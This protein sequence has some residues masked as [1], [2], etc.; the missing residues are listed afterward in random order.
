MLLSPLASFLLGLLVLAG[1]AADVGI[2]FWTGARSVE[3]SDEELTVYRG[4][5]LSRQSV[6]RSSVAHVRVRKVAGACVVRL[7]TRS[8][9]Y[10][11]LSEVAFPREEFRRFLAAIRTWER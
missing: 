9:R 10:L 3:L 1:F 8:G 6:P 4:P 7:R 2:W 5:R 11:R